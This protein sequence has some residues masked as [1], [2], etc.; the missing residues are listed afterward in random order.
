[1]IEHFNDFLIDVRNNFLSKRM[2]EVQKLDDYILNFA[3]EN[4]KS[5]LFSVHPESICLTLSK[6]VD[7]Q[8]EQIPFLKENICG[9]FLKEVEGIEGEPIAKFQFAGFFERILIFEGLKRCANI[10]LLDKD[11][12]VLWALRTFKG[13]FRRGIPLEKWKLPPKGENKNYDYISTNPQKI[14]DFLLERNKSKLRKEIEGKINFLKR[15][16]E[17]L[18]NEY[19]EGEKFLN[20]E[21]IG[22]SLLN[23]D[24][25]HRRGLSKIEVFDYSKTDSQQI[26]VQLD[27]KLSILE[28]AKAFFKLSKKGK[29]R[30][31][32][33]PRRIKECEEEIA[34]LKERIEE[35]ENISSLEPLIKETRVIPRKEKE[36]RKNNKI[37]KEVVKVEFSRNF[38]GYA[39]KNARGNEIVSFKLSS[40]EDFWFHC[41]DYKGA[42]LII[43]NPE[44]LDV[45][46]F[47][48]EKEALKFSA[49]HSSAPKGNVVEVIISKAKYL[50][51]VKGVLGAVYVSKFKKKR[52]D[53]T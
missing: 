38:V 24:A 46:P 13:E 16:I 4:K 18:S 48:V 27:P 41:A 19:K 7:F 34:K 49:E 11:G 44:K 22:K 42:H 40:G 32:R 25:L 2:V 12:V 45:L 29:E 33:I 50:S 10:L 31:S 15:K 23:C 9:L 43:K 37:P 52:I 6:K 28:N 1:M 8:C 47:D 51:K 53:L 30:I 14:Y 21:N 26:D 5:V 35:I 36:K 20:F 39:G 3:F 17:I